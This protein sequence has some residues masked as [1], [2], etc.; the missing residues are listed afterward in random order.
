MAKTTKV[1]NS[2]KT[3]TQL[4]T[5]LSVE[6]TKYGVKGGYSGKVGKF[7]VSGDPESVNKFLRI[8]C[9][10]GKGAYPFPVLSAKKAF[11]QS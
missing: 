9:L 4:K 1:D 11:E 7:V 10:R 8:V 6:A 3:T 5:A 2:T